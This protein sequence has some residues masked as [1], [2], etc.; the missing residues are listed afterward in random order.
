MWKK[1]SLEA[2]RELGDQFSARLPLWLE[3]DGCLAL[4]FHLNMNML[5]CIQSLSWVQEFTTPWTAAHQV[6]LSLGI[7][8]TRIL[9]EFPSPPPGNLPNSG[10][11]PRSPA[12]WVDP[13]ISEPPREPKNTGVVA[14]PFSALCNHMGCGM[15]GLPVPHNLLEFFCPSQSHWVFLSL[16][17]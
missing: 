16:C 14:Y 17:P 10:I 12:L 5:C 8:Q 7:L 4:R 15:P 3:A 2:D 1:H 6:P 11:E 9:E 13:L